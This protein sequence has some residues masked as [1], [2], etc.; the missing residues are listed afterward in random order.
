M[1]RKKL[2]FEGCINTQISF[3][4]KKNQTRIKL[5]RD[6]SDGEEDY[7]KHPAVRCVL[8]VSNS[9]HGDL[10][11]LSNAKGC[12]IEKLSQIHN[13]HQRLLHGASRF[14]VSHGRCF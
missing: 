7:R 10:T 14:P 6:N 4:T 3:K 13:I 12:V 1:I 2:D 9:Q 5:K 11:P 8:H